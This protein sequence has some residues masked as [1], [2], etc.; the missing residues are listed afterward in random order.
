MNGESV[1]TCM[2]AE[3]FRPA[4]L[5]A[6]AAAAGRVPVLQMWNLE[7]RSRSDSV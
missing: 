1:Q 3:P 2:L 5:M 6:T 7:G 4:G